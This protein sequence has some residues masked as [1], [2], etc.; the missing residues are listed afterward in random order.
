MKFKNVWAWN[1]LFDN[2]EV[3]LIKEYKLGELLTPIIWGY[4]ENV[5]RRGY[6]PDGL[7]E[8]YSKVI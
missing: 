6:F 5:T 3:D 2:I 7:F 8:R 4:I 1:D